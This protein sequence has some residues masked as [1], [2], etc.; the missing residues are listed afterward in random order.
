MALLPLLFLV[1][2][3]V[4]ICAP[5]C[6][7]C[8]R[9]A[10][11]DDEHEHAQ[12]GAPGEGVHDTGCCC[13]QHGCMRGCCCVG[14]CGW[15]PR[16][17]RR[18]SSG[19]A[20]FTTMPAVLFVAAIPWPFKTAKMVLLQL[21]FVA[22]SVGLQR[23]AA[24]LDAA[25]ASQSCILLACI[26]I[27]AWSSNVLFWSVTHAAAVAL[28]ALL[29][30]GAFH[31]LG[32]EDAGA[33]NKPVEAV[34]TPPAEK[35]TAAAVPSPLGAAIAAAFFL[36]TLAHYIIYVGSGTALL[37]RGAGNGLEPELATLV[38]PLLPWI[39]SE[40]AA[41]ALVPRREDWASFVLA[42]P[43]QQVAAGSST[44]RRAVGFC[45]VA[46]NVCGCVLFFGM[47]LGAASLAG[48]SLLLTLLPWWIRLAAGKLRRWS[49]HAHERSRRNFHAWL[50]FA[51][52]LHV[53]SLFLF[54]QSCIPVRGI[55]GISLVVLL[56]LTDTAEQLLLH[57]Q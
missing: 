5:L 37:V 26:R 10:D 20:I 57:G 22:M 39:F 17:F 47:R 32:V 48:G 40:F 6:L 56:F 31:F 3:P 45:F 23:G 25:L 18:F 33:D 44:R 50:A 15:L 28:P 2:M 41:M 9:P 12:P 19:H 42:A 11:D 55:Q 21:S 1:G 8:T 7:C 43:R 35:A 29:L 53:A 14:C 16:Q 24:D 54:W 49:A 46:A 36:S 34:V 52:F 13:G 38:L 27:A 4:A 30:Q 51:F